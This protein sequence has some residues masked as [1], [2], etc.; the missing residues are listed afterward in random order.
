MS[1]RKS[2]SIKK[3]SSVHAGNTGATAP[4]DEDTYRLASMIAALSEQ[5]EGECNGDNGGDWHVV[6]QGMS[7]V[8]KQ[9]IFSKMLRDHPAA[10]GA[11]DNDSRTRS[12][13]Y[14]TTTDE[15]EENKSNAI[16]RQF[17][18]TAAKILARRRGCL[19]PL[20]GSSQA[21]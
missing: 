15:E 21:P 9:E 16:G 5:E 6:I 4:V 17:R 13:T 10:A 11:V 8:K 2:S 19:P 1:S 20:N 14:T 3:T 18:A 7:I 12:G